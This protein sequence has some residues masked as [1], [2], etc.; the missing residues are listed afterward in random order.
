MINRRIILPS[1]K[2]RTWIGWVVTATPTPTQSPHLYPL[3]QA[4]TQYGP[5]RPVKMGVKNLA[6]HQYFAPDSAARNELHQ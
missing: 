5:K 1:V 6:S 4:S 3:K 2:P